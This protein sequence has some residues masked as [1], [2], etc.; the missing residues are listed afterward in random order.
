LTATTV[1][2]T[3]ITG[4]NVKSLAQGTNVTISNDGAGTYTINSSGSSVVSP[5]VYAGTPASINS[6]AEYSN[7]QYWFGY[8][9]YD[10]D[11]YNYDIEFVINQDSG[12]GNLLHFCWD[13]NV[14]FT[15]YQVMYNDWDATGNYIGSNPTAAFMYTQ[16]VSGFQ[17][18]YK[19]TLRAVPAVSASNYNRLMLEGTMSMNYQSSGSRAF[20]APARSSRTIISYAGASQN[21][22]AQF[23]GSHSFSM[24]AT[25]SSY[26]SNN[27]CN[28]RITRV[29]KNLPGS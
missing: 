1:T 27:P 3:T 25:V 11:N 26:A 28:M 19:G 20:S 9:T 4:W 5:T 17:A 6:I 21:S 14:D 12:N 13:N 22:I 7:N 8:S 10:F 29:M 2:P 23:N 16:N 15:Y 18:S 24:W